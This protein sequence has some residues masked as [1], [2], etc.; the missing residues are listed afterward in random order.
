MKHIL[1][2][3]A[4]CGFVAV[5][6]GLSAQNTNS[7]YFLEGYTYRY[8]MNP[9]FANERNFVSMP[10]LGD[11]NVA[12]RGNLHLSSVL[13]NVDGRTCLFTNPSV[14]ASE[15]MNSLHDKNRI[16][17]DVKLN[18]ISA[19]FKAFGGYNTVS[20]NARAGVNVNVPKAFFSLAKEGI[21]NRTYDIRN[22]SARGIGYGELAFGHSRDIS[23]VPGLRVGA[24]VKFLIGVANVDAYFNEAKLTLGENGW[25]GLTN[26]DIYA[27][28]G[29]LQYEHDVNDA[30]KEYVSGVTMDGDG[31]IGPNGFGMAFDLG[32]TYSW[33]D[34]NFS[35][36]VLDLGWISFSDTKY[37][38]TNGTR[39]V[40]T[41]AY[42]FNADD[43][44]PNSFD[45]EWKRLRD[46]FNELYQLSDNG[47][48]G[49][50][51]TALAA[52]LNLGVEYT[53]PYYRKLHFGF[54]SSTRIAGR[55]SWSEARFSA[56]VAPVNCFSA[57][58]NVAFSSFGTSFGWLLNFHHTGFNF[59]LGMNHTLGKVSKQWVPL[60]SNA[61]L[62]MGINFPF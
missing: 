33:R 12:L 17:S 6:T 30:G 42:T 3:L 50:R 51:S 58:A 41:D 43:D 35:A 27:N 10:G 44:A 62:N 45:N 48:I 34:F 36:A 19:G 20:I 60:S 1:R 18:V 7:G 9:A 8:Q 57:D 11:V 37:A 32:A 26:A 46:N 24:S 28:V 53:L 38:S 22:L 13:Y 61:S 2:K 31:S 16:G 21:S 40:N 52:T 23:Q 14:S 5:A 25:E 47:N 15:V 59:F 56:N 4:I 54:L 55:Y 29:S 49:G 39:Y